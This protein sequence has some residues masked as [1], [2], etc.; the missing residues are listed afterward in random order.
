MV[1]VLLLLLLLLLLVVVVVSEEEKENSTF[2]EMLQILVVFE[3]GLRGLEEEIHY[4]CYDNDL[5]LYIDGQWH[6]NSTQFTRIIGLLNNN[7]TM[8]TV[9]RELS[10]WNCLFGKYSDNGYS[11]YSD[12]PTHRYSHNGGS[13]PPWWLS[14][15]ASERRAWHCH[16]AQRAQ[17]MARASL[18]LLSVGPARCRP[19]CC[20]F[21][22]KQ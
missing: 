11:S 14:G 21:R 13:I 4:I 20:D 8:Q 6:I 12:T 5:L 3:Y 1:V 19:L 17:R 18:Q 16:V 7:G 15:N 2:E 10:E 9:N 22:A